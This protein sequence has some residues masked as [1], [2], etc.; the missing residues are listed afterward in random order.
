[1]LR[2]VESSAHGRVKAQIGWKRCCEFVIDVLRDCYQHCL[3]YWLLL[4]AIIRVF[5]VQPTA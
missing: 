3:N 4:E 5:L 2:A 1:M